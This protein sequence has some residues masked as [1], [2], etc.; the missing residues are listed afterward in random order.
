MH[1]WHVH[2]VLHC[3]TT[4]ARLINTGHTAHPTRPAG[5]GRVSFLDGEVCFLD[6]KV[7]FL[8]RKVSFLDRKVWV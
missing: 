2:A 5:H 7:S 3:D 6:R 1:R 4:R 8:D